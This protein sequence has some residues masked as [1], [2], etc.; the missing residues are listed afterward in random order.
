MGHSQMIYDGSKGRHQLTK[1][2]YSPFRSSHF[3]LDLR[4]VP[5]MASGLCK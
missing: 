1:L 5:E 2:T 3:A 4:S